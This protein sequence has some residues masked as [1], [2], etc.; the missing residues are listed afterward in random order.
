MVRNDIEDH[1]SERLSSRQCFRT[2]P[3]N[4]SF[5]IDAGGLLL[6]AD[7]NREG[8][9]FSRRQMLKLGLLAG[10]SAL[11]LRDR[12]AWGDG[13]RS[14][15]DFW[16]NPRSPATRPFIDP[17]P[18]P[19]EVN[20]VSP[21][22]HDPRAVGGEQPTEAD[23]TGAKYCKIV[24]EE[25]FAK[26][27][28]DLPATRVWRY[29][30]LD[31]KNTPTP[32]APLPVGEAV[33]PFF[34]F[35]FG[36]TRVPVIARFLNRLPA[37]HQGFG[38]PN[39]TV[40]LHGGHD[41]E[42][43]DGFP[44]NLF[45]PNQQFSQFEAW[46]YFYS[47]QDPGFS[48][49]APDPLDRPSTLWYHDHRLEFTAQNV[50]RGLA[51]V[52]LCFDELDT[53]SETTGLKLPSGE[54]D[55]PL[56]LQDRLFAPDGSLVYNSFEHDG[57]LGDKY[58]VNN[59]VQPYKFVRRR[60]YRLRLLN[61]SNARFFRV[62]LTKAS[63]QA[64]FFDQI[65]TE[66]GLLSAPIRNRQWVDVAPAVRAEIVVDF[67]Q[68]QDGDE[69]FLENRLAQSEG[70]GPEGVLRQG[71]QL[72]KFKF[73]GPKL[74]DNPI[75]DKL[76]EVRRISTAELSAAVRKTFVF[77]DENGWTIN[78][79]LAGQLTRPITKSRQGAGEIW[80]LVN[81]GGGWSH[82]IHIHHDFF[83]ILRRNGRTPPLWELDGMARR[84]MF[85]L[86]PDDTIDV[87]VRFNDFPG[88][89]VFHCHNLEHEDMAMMARF[90]VIP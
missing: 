40:H 54:Y 57:F 76:R 3:L 27:H 59:V 82:P 36:D 13:G 12:H 30:A 60:K 33:S 10:G 61:G 35:Q 45:G 48:R 63:G 6:L 4:G 7:G 26:M 5:W 70:T 46:D 37:N 62:F 77:G 21:F 38:D 11:L 84:E 81:D 15:F 42:A 78:E 68:F 87:F 39:T 47:L 53:G 28:T 71:P 75:P 64:F 8:A 34:R 65:A 24:E 69:V 74:A 51:G 16:D 18:T 55:L 72:L 44:T 23:F 88:K 58:L 32:T 83:H 85:V 90:D 79:R 20:S 1:W 67:S 52:A 73:F 89:F 66:A 25:V 43:S 80:R 14:S 17:L 41:N 29:R 49:G 2:A 31:D 50:Y 19:G 56:L 9:M 86:G 22:V